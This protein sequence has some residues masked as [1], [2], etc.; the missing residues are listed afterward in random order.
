MKKRCPHCRAGLPLR[1]SAWRLG[2][3]FYCRKCGQGVII[4]NNPRIGYLTAL[5]IIFANATIDDRMF[6]YGLLIIAIIFA[7]YFYIFE[8]KPISIDEY[9]KKYP[10]S[11][12]SRQFISSS[13]QEGDSWSVDN[14]SCIKSCS[15]HADV[16]K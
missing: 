15:D 2:S 16:G 10:N 7:I 4:E 6:F 14:H 12:L 13:S 9:I 11:I 5:F 8:N 3:P 1:Q